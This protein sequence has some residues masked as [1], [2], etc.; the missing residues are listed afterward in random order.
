LTPSVGGAHFRLCVR[1][2]EGLL[3]RDSLLKSLPLRMIISIS[4]DISIDGAVN[5]ETEAGEQ[6]VAA[7]AVLSVSYF[8]V[9]AGKLLV[10]RNM[11]LTL[12]MASF[13]FLNSSSGSALRPY[14][15]PP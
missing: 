2:N 15:S 3:G 7:A 14:P 13:V 10:L 4:I 8:I 11:P 9:T 6:L 5:S 1:G 12:R